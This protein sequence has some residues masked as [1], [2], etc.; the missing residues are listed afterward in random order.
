MPRKIKIIAGDVEAYAELNETKTA[1][2]I[3]EA[4]PIDGRANT[5]GDEIYFSIP[6]KLGGEDPKEVVSEGDIGYW[7]P[8]SAF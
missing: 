3:W 6:V 7:P 8:G 1:D 5:W 4:L 2:A